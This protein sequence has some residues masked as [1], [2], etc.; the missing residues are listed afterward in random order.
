M[1]R[2]LRPLYIAVLA[3]L[4]GTIIELMVRFGGV[5]P[6]DP[7]LAVIFGVSII[8]AA[9]LLSWAAE[10]IQLD[11]S[12]GMAL[13]LLALIAILPEYVVDASFAW[14]AA[15]DP[16][17]AE[18]A[19]ANMTGANR[20]LIG[21]FWPLVVG[22]FWYRSRKRVVQLDRSNALEI[23][24]LLLATIYAFVIP[25]KGYISLVDCAVLV[26]IFILY[27]FQLAK[28]PAEE[29][30]LIGP[31][32][33]IG[34]MEPGRRRRIVAI[35]GVYSA[36]I[37]LLVA[38]PFAEALIGTGTQ[39]GVDE[40]L[41][42]QW[43]AP[44][45]SEAPEL[46]VVSIFAWR[47]AATAALGALVS[48]KINQWTLL[49]AM[50]PL[51]YTIASGEIAALP[52]GHAEGDN[53]F[54]R[55]SEEIFLTAAQSL[56]AVCLL[57][58]LRLGLPGSVALF[59]LFVVS[60]IWPDYHTEVGMIYLALALVVLFTERHHVRPT[61]RSVREVLM[62]PRGTTIPSEPS[63]IGTKSPSHGD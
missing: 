45:A 19:V 38:E 26:G 61:F 20:L 8:G 23:L 53:F 59:A 44:L 25:F 16:S 17:Q 58:D 22:I 31:A 13:A 33:T 6:P 1:Q 18:Y 4:P 12:A 40:F 27:M 49:I 54:S 14:K 5:H 11:V 52:L 50:L 21:A 35:M 24:T 43:L 37:I 47:G 30:H 60:F 3:T 36:A 9:F 57:L 62:T 46:V 39:I 2:A 55:Q 51:I 15:S 42:V 34:A 41:L 29:P 7:L 28:L 48:S 10:V 56:F 63:E 32:Q